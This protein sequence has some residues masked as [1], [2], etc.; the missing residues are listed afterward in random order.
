MNAGQLALCP[1]TRTAEWVAAILQCCV[2][3][4]VCGGE[5]ANLVEQENI[6]SA[7]PQAAT[8]TVDRPGYRASR[9]KHRLR[10]NGCWRVVVGP[11]D[12]PILVG[13]VHRRSLSKKWEA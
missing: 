8:A 1:M 3:A 5:S 12:D 4:L 2:E 13:F 11:A 6:G 10:H 7:A 9:T